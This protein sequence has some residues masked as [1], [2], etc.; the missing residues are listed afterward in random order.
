MNLM[1]PFVSEKLILKNKLVYPPIRIKR[2]TNGYANYFHLAHYMSFAVGQVGLIIMEECAVA[3]DA[4]LGSGALGL[5][6]DD[7][8]IMLRQIVGML[9][10]EGS[11]VAIQLNHA[12]NKSRLESDGIIR[13]INALTQA[14]IIELFSCYTSA[15]ERAVVAGFDALEIMASHEFLIS[16]FIDRRTNHRTDKYADPVI[17][18]TELLTA[19]RTAWPEDKAIILRVG[20]RYCEEDNILFTQN[21]LHHI[22]H[23]IDIVHISNGGSRMH[24]TNKGIAYQLDDTREIKKQCRKPVIVVGGIHDHQ[25]ADEILEHQYAD[26]IAVGRG[27]LRNPNWFLEYLFKYDRKLIPRPYIR[28]FR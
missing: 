11:K 24:G 12:G 1:Q 20:T 6:E 4:R 22:N 27:L 8:T 19:V 3:V 25:L 5:Y 10:H 17:F 16:Q 2:A 7:H 18:L 9:Q 26:L 13:D 28:A 23:L 15:A 21:I 14:D